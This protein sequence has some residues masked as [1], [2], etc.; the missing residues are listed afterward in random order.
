MRISWLVLLCLVSLAPAACKRDAAVSTAPTVDGAICAACN[1]PINDERFAG[2]YRL[3]DGT[4]KSFDDPTCLF[5]S[6][7]AQYGEPLVIRF[8]DHESDRWLAADQTW[9]ARTDATKSPRGAG[10]AAYASFAA[11]QDAVTSAGNG[12]ILSYE[13]ASKQIGADAPS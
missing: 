3:S 10:W 12:E 6:L 13:Q 8:R 4:V 2:Q 1:S 5:R 11:A 7:R 9:F